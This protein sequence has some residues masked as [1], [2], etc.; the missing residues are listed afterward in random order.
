M[1]TFILILFSLSLQAQSILG[2]KITDK[3]MHDQAG[4]IISGW[5]SSSV[6][7]WELKPWLSVGAG[8]GAATTIGVAKEIIWD[9]W[10]GKGTPDPHDAGATIFGGIRMSIISRIG[11]DYYEKKMFKI[12]SLRFQFD[13][14]NINKN[15]EIK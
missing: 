1:K 11:F 12:D 7:Y 13:S 6:Y 5:A 4:M 3:D 9:T 8:I 14:L 2:Y 10:L 15:L